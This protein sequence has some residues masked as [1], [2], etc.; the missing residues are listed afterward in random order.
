MNEKNLVVCDKELRYAV[1]LGEN[2]SLR[3]EFALRVQVCTSMDSMMQFKQNRKLHI[4]I[5]DEAFTYEER[6]KMGAEQTFVLTKETCRDLGEKEREI[7]KFQ[8][9]DRILAEVFETYCGQRENGLI[10]KKNTHK[11]RLLAVYSPIHRIG[12]TTFAIALGKELAKTD[13]TLYLNL[14]EYADV[15]GRFIEADEKNLSDL[16]YFM[17]QEE[18]DMALR[19][20]TMIAH[21]GDLEYIPPVLLGADLKEIS[22][23]EWQEFLTSILEETVYE[24]VILDLGESIQGLLEILQFCDKVYMPVLEDGISRQKV[25]RFDEMLRQMGLGIVEQ[26]IDRFV[27]AEDMDIYAKKL[28]QEET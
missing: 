23:E 7:Y 10:K 4:L 21:I 19:I 2:I 28:I 5:V 14:E 11:K 8:S 13:R 24:T 22:L 27:A 26:K 17:R 15:G 9:A 18:E 3:T 1:G 20:S 12:K 25:Q 16:F 6:K